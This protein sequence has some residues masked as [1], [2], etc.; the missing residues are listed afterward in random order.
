MGE[1]PGR[2][3]ASQPWPTRGMC[4]SVNASECGAREIREG[5]KSKERSN[6]GS[7]ETIELCVSRIEARL[8]KLESV[9]GL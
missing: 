1:G 4:S 2:G 9:T 5:T 7:E 6:K 3:H 8:D